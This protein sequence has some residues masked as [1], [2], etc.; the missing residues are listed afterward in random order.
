M[1]LNKTAFAATI[2]CGLLGSSLCAEP[3]LNFSY[4]ALL[5]MPMMTGWSGGDQRFY[6]APDSASQDE[7]SRVRA[8]VATFDGSAT[9]NLK[10]LIASVE[11]GQGGYDAVVRSAWIKPA[12]PP[13]QMTIGEIYAWIEATPDQNHAIGRYQII[14]LT[15]RGLV[16]KSGLPLSTR[17]SQATQDFFADLLLAEAGYGKFLKGSL[18]QRQFLINLAG[19][20]AGLPT[21]SGRSYY[22][23]VAGNRAVISWKVFESSVTQIFSGK[24]A[25]VALAEVSGF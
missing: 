21:P 7:V 10:T 14:P 5:P 6:L 2:W 12:K 17:Y 13:S 1:P 8:L 24:S 18:S 19:I 15:L 23:G 9:D 16:R 25:K 20:W 11:A 3:V 4:D 22:H